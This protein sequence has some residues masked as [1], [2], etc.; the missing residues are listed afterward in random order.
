M[1]KLTKISDFEE[2][3]MASLPAG[4]FNYIQKSAGNGETFNANLNAFNKYSLLPKV[5]N[6]VQK[7]DTSVEVLGSVISSPIMIAP[8]AWHKI[9]SQNGE[10]DTVAA[11]KAFNIS[12][13]ISSFST[14]DF[15]EISSDLSNCWYQI[16][17]SRDKQL[18]KKWINKAESAGCS[19]I[20][21]T[22]DAPLGCSICKVS[23]SDAPSTE[24]PPAAELPL[25]P[26]DP[27]LPYQNLDEYYPQY[28]GSASGW[29]DI[30]DI[31]SFTKLPVILKGILHPADAEKALETGV[32]GIIV[33]NHGGRQLD[34]AIASLDALALIPES[35]KNT[36]EVY[37]DE[38]IRTGGDIFKALA[39]GAKSV[40]IGRAAIYGL[41][42]NGKEEMLDVLSTLQKELIT[43]MH[44]CGCSSVNEIDKSLLYKL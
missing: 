4:T 18:M 8:S 16:L 7:V 43:I 39:L 22:I 37:M 41:A 38:G 31:I 40:L 25:L 35:V 9:Y 20:V 28:M 13:V 17:M 3:A 36:I 12:Y 10:C 26:T 33:S 14:L 32:R 24:F 5:L 42:V 6:N 27:A 2:T 34:N 19:A 15:S 11:A 44:M 23:D 1:K 29:E 21:I 30:R